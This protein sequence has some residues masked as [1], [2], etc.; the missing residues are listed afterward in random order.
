M[1]VVSDYDYYW[2]FEEETPDDEDEFDED[3]EDEYYEDEDFGDDFMN[4]DFDVARYI[5]FIE[6]FWGSE[7]FDERFL[8]FNLYVDD[9]DD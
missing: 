3:G 6:D 5:A 8:H 1:Q 9:I 4:F 2:H 7:Y